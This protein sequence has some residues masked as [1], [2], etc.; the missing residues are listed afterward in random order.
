MLWVLRRLQDGDASEL[1]G[2]PEEPGGALACKADP[3]EAPDRL[4]P[5]SARPNARIAANDNA[6]PDAVKTSPPPPPRSVSTLEPPYGDMSSRRS[7]SH[8]LLQM[9]ITAEFDKVKRTKP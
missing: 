7:P 3:P 6:D 2:I 5:A 9:P 4:A 1:H 8:S